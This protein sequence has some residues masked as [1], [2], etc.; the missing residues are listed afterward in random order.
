MDAADRIAQAG[1]ARAP[2]VRLA[3][4]VS[5]ASRVEPALLRAAR[6]HCMTGVPASAEADLW[7]GPLV[8]V[9]GPREII[10][11]KDVARTLRGELSDDLRRA[12]AL[13]EKAH[14]ALP[15]LVRL[16]EALLWAAAAPDQAGDAAAR[17]L[18]RVIK[19]VAA[20]GRP[21]LARWALGFLARVPAEEQTAEMRLLERMAEAQIF[22]NWR[23]MLEDGGEGAAL[24]PEERGVLARILPRVPVGVRLLAG[25]LE[26]REP[27]AEGSEQV[28]VPATDPRVLEVEWT[29]SDGS[30]HRERALLPRGETRGVPGVTRP[31]VLATLTGER[32]AITERGAATGRY[33]DA[34]MPFLVHAHSPR[35]SRG[36]RGTVV[37]ANAVIVPGSVLEGASTPPG[38]IF[39]NQGRDLGLYDARP[40]L[41]S[42]HETQSLYLAFTEH[43]PGHPWH[44]APL[45]GPAPEQGT[46]C[47]AWMPATSAHPEGTWASFHVGEALPSG[48]LRLRP[49]TAITGPLAEI[50]ASPVL[51]VE[52]AR[53]LGIFRT[54]VAERDGPALPLLVPA[55]RIAAALASAGPSTE[56]TES[57][58]ADPALF[59][60]FISYA[61]ADVLAARSLQRSVEGVLTSR[62][63]KSEVFLEVDHV[64]PGAPWEEIVRGSLRRADLVLALV[65][66]EYTT[67]HAQVELGWAVQDDRR[68]IPV[69]LRGTRPLPAPLAELKALPS[70]GPLAE[71]K[72]QGRAFE[73]VAE[74]IGNIVVQMVEERRAAGAPKPAPASGA[75][76]HALVIAI[77]GD[78]EDRVSTSAEVDADA[79]TRWLAD[80]DGGGVSPERVRVLHNAGRAEVERVSDTLAEQRRAK[81]QPLGRRL[82][83]FLSG[84]GFRA[85]TGEVCILTSASGSAEPG[86]IWP[87]RFADRFIEERLFDEVLVFVSTVPASAAPTEVTLPMANASRPGRGRRLLMAGPGAVPRSDGGIL[88][89]PFTWALINGLSGSGAEEGVVT[90]DTLTTYIS[91][92]LGRDLGSVADLTVSATDEQKRWI[93][94]RVNSERTRGGA[95]IDFSP[96][97]MGSEATVLNS[98]AEHVAHAPIGP[99]PLEV[100]LPAG[101]YTT[102]VIGAGVEERFEVLPGATT[103]VSVRW[104]PRTL[105]VL[106]AGTA[107]KRLPEPVSLASKALGNAL[108]ESGFRLVTGTW[109]G[110]DKQITRE[111]LK[112]LQRVSIDPHEM[113][114]VVRTPR[115]PGGGK[116]EVVTV[117][118][119]EASFD[120]AIRRSDAVVLIGGVGG[121]W[122]VFRRA[123]EAGKPVFP[124]AGTGGDAAHG[125]E[126]LRSSRGTDH[127]SLMALDLPVRTPAEARELAVVVIARLLELVGRAGSGAPPSSGPKVD[128]TGRKAPPGEKGR[129]RK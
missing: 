106:L 32:Y 35:A 69:M 70:H 30:A 126:E 46:R 17:E 110:V 1:G 101:L 23:A 103:R 92:V 11:F 83:I 100:K 75:D 15:P 64:P 31:V 74:E 90:A 42:P 2:A 125:Y 44:P 50:A 29:G 107:R 76:D 119:E 24:S 39:R 40:V 3:R 56:P 91:A 34:A 54:F 82:Y 104:R 108:A 120:E 13:V 102:G 49:G 109:E 73:E 121:T 53:F 87:R 114:T 112:R 128:D 71:A 93:L 116:G 37:G 98:R 99:N 47:V 78:V 58:A 36:A 5:L 117:D 16:E 25:G 28:E 111:F 96:I 12:R 80:P 38:V 52:T 33:S 45:D 113:L 65:S 97:F 21:G 63:V 55:T 59:R 66:P 6:L 77:A 18:R 72:D 85:N 124:L 51:D 61:R 4:W 22:G 88:P 27:A 68:L 123:R 86:F 95:L 8:Q 62:G 7:F 127:P 94:A 57:G 60:I 14:E 10:L 41:Q 89:G 79:F 67:S 122:E 48:D 43:D 84:T 105:R 129:G 9:R 19:A 26:L 20:G 81:D 118:S 115:Q